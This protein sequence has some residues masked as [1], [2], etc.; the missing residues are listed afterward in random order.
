MF[1]AWCTPAVHRISAV[2]PFR[3]DSYP[4]WSIAS[5]VAR[6]RVGNGFKETL[7]ASVSYHLSKRTELYLAGDYMDEA[8]RRVQ[9]RVDVRLEQPPRTD[10]R[11]SDAVLIL[12]RRSAQSRS[13]PAVVAARENST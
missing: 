8:A 2:P 6:A 9:G 5:Y 13:R 7:Y 1:L 4:Q 3:I 12:A 10:D 11:Y